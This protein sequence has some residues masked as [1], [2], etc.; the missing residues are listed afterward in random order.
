MGGSAP[1]AMQGSDL[2]FSS[3]LSGYHCSPLGSS[4][5]GYE[6]S[7][8]ALLSSQMGGVAPRKCS[9]GEK[10]LQS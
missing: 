7:V 4:L 2:G 10:P 5:L 9:P 8:N 6:S 1:Q 3:G